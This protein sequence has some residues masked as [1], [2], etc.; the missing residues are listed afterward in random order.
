[1]TSGDSSG[2]ARERLLSMNDE[3]TEAT[4]GGGVSR[5]VESVL[6]GDVREGGTDR[7]RCHRR[8]CARGA[9][10][11]VD[12]LVAPTMAL[13]LGSRRRGL[14]EFAFVVS[15]VRFEYGKFLAACVNA[16]AT[17]F[18]RGTPSCAPAG[19]TAS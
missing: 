10:A 2:D 4:H 11:V 9:D 13:T 18:W 3:E 17:V 15:G 16:W 1:M 5:G 12:A 19:W 8:A 6:R 7:D 14:E